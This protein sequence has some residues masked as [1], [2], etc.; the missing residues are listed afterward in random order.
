MSELADFQS[1]NNIPMG[2]FVGFLNSS[3]DLTNADPVRP[4]NG[5][6]LIKI[7]IYAVL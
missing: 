6:L 3:L 5:E 1:G 4:K 7:H 2:S